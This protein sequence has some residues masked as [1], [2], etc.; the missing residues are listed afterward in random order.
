[1]LL[2]L[3][4][5]ASFSLLFLMCGLMLYFYWSALSQKDSGD[6]LKGKERAKDSKRA[7]SGSNNGRAE[8]RWYTEIWCNQSPKIRPLTHAIKGRWVN[9][10][11][12]Y[13]YEHPGKTQYHLQNQ[14]VE[15]KRLGFKCLW[16]KQGRL[17][18]RQLEGCFWGSEQKPRMKLRPGGVAGISVVAEASS[19]SDGSQGKSLWGQK[20]RY[21]IWK[22]P[23]QE[24]GRSPGH[25]EWEK[26]SLKGKT[27]PRREE[28]SRHPNNH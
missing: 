6:W 25:E 7:D 22:S 21:W 12:G 27:K 9:E 4:S 8:E 11:Q 3:I 2:K 28:F 1:M 13:L 26:N 18:R 23:P 14:K 16:E 20:S 24:P 17:P 5:L 19:E 10:H 15:R